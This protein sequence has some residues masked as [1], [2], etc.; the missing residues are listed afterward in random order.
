M[1]NIRFVGKIYDNHSLS[2]VTRK[3]CLSIIEGNKANITI[4]PLDKMNPAAKVNKEE[5]KTLRSFINKKLPKIDIEVRHSYP[6]IT[7]WPTIEEKDMKIVYIQPWEFNRIPLEWKDIFQNFA[8]LVIA[9]SNWVVSTYINSG[10]NPSKIRKV[11]NGYD[12][13]VFNT[14]RKET[15]LVDKSKFIF[16]FVGN[17]QYRKGI[18]IL[19]QA[20]HKSFVKADNAVLFIKDTPTIYGQTNLLDNI[21]QIQYKSGC[22]KIVYNDDVLSESEMAALYSN[23][24]VI[25]H[26][27]RGEG[28][29]MHIQEAMA[30]GALP[31]VTG[32]G[33]TEDFVNDN[34]GIR[35]AASKVIIDANDPKYFIGKP[36]D[37]YASMGHHFWVPEPSIEDLGQKMRFLYYHHERESILT[38]VNNASLTTWDQAST[39]FI[40]SLQTLDKESIPARYK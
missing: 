19:L 7:V 29:G 6:P 4:T 33:A 35:I 1:L 37:S 25:V 34:C 28:F 17:P 14:K 39:E 9:P 20:W 12:P 24:D 13:A 18:D 38:K 32:I 3:L 36:G 26:P 16:T 23:T 5:L 2:I 10:I 22:A 11:P 30:C 40:S 21:I 8:D 31:L 15:A 27:Y